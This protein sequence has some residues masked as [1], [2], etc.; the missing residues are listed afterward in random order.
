MCS[1][2]VVVA[3]HLVVVIEKLFIELRQFFS[4][5]C[6]LISFTTVMMLGILSPLYKLTL[7]LYTA[8]QNIN[9][10]TTWMVQ[11]S[12]T[13]HF[14]KNNDAKYFKLLQQLGVGPLSTQ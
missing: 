5:D 4:T 14:V 13:V 6:I 10:S 3:V 7:L 12:N 2:P 1:K 8:T 9:V 11:K